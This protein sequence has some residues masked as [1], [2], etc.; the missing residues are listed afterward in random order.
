MKKTV[1]LGLALMLLVLT[2]CLG[3][4]IPYQDMQPQDGTASVYVYRPSSFINSAETMILEINGVESGLLSHGFYL[5]SF[6]EP[7]DAQLV[8][9]KNVIPYNEYGSISLKSI[10]SGRSYYVKADPVAFGG[11]DMILMDEKIGRQEAS[12]TKLF[13]N[14]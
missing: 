8:L 4:Q 10:Q 13:V 2:G 11:F 5:H 6:V 9:K 1:A 3:K 14:E 12:A 7:G